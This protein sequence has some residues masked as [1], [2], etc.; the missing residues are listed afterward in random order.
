MH[1]GE[2]D[3]ALLDLEIRPGLDQN[4]QRI[5]MTGEH[6]LDH[7]SAPGPGIPTVYIGPRSKGQ[8]DGLQAASSSCLQ[9]APGLTSSHSV[10]LSKR[11]TR[12][13][14]SAAMPKP[15]RSRFRSTN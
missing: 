8:C 10:K 2:A 5:G 14:R 6:S 3:R 15:E 7:R 4:L 13:R 11:L 12:R 9:Q 1:R